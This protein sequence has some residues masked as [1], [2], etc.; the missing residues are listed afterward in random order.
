MPRKKYYKYAHFYLTLGL[1]IVLLG[2]STTYFSRLGEFTIPYHIHGISATLWMI[3]LIIQPYLFQKGKLKAHRY[4]GWSSLLLIP[5]I[6]ICGIIMMRMMIQGQENY[7]PNLVYQLAFIDACTLVSF[8]LLYALGL[9]Y[10]KKLK[11]HSKFMVATI[12]G[13][14]LPALARMFLFTFGIASNFNQALTYSYL[15]LEIS[16][17]LIIWKERGEKEIRLTYIPFLIF[18]LIQHGLMYYS[19]EWAWWKVLMDNFANYG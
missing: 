15:A 14:L 5:T 11:L 4:L 8:A 10:R 6:V 1:V 16:L 3:L 19:D 13:P 18:I 12:F 9:I 17:L 7:P 2:F